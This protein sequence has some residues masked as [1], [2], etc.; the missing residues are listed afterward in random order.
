M[1]KELVP[2]LS[3]NERLHDEDY[4]C[5]RKL[6]FKLCETA[7]A[8]HQQVIV[9]AAMSAGQ[10]LS[11]DWRKACDSFF[12]ILKVELAEAAAND[13][14]VAGKAGLI[15]LAVKELLVAAG[16]WQGMEDRTTI[17]NKR[18]FPDWAADLECWQQ[19]E[20]KRLKIASAED[21]LFRDEE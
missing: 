16:V 1:C 2:V 3:P 5:G 10:R 9:R 20:A 13:S 8:K 4:T 15:A 17:V 12:A 7:V 6:F 18:R 11:G 21:E 19:A 14:Y